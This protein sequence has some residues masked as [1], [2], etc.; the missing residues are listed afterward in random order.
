MKE[1][2]SKQI[3]NYNSKHAKGDERGC[4]DALQSSNIKTITLLGPLF[5]TSSTYI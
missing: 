1:S 5:E 4:Q 3:W 2:H